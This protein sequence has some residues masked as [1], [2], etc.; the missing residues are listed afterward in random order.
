MKKDFLSELTVLSRQ[1][2]RRL[3]T[4]L[5]KFRALIEQSVAPPALRLSA[6]GFDLIAEYKRR[7]PALGKLA[8]PTRDMGRQLSAYAKGGAAMISV[9]TETA[10]FDGSMLHLSA[11]ARLMKQADIPVMRKDFLV[12]PLQLYEAR[13][14]GAGGVLLI[15][16]ILDDPALENML[17]CAAELGLFVLAEAFDR[18]DL[19]RLAEVSVAR[20]N[21]QIL[22]GVNCRDLSTLELKPERFFELAPLLPPGLP[23]VAESGIGNSEDLPSL[24]DAGYR[25]ALIGGA[26]MRHARPADFLSACLAGVRNRAARIVGGD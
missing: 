3:L 26:L 8:R 2:A 9:L 20:E 17:D 12:D 1:R 15:I 21:Q 10:H 18:T 6:D 4:D 19:T 24:A 22:A 5:D 14:A 11:A 23:A 13:A 16:R 25:L 7:S